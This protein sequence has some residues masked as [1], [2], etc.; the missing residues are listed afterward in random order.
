M[1]TV[2]FEFT[3]YIWLGQYTSMDNNKYYYMFK[4]KIYKLG[5]FMEGGRRKKTPMED[6]VFGECFQKT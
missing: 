2:V 4:W 3:P 5:R 1:L 6:D